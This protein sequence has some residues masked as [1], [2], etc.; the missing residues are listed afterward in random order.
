MI[1]V[2]FYTVLFTIMEKSVFNT[3]PSYEPPFKE[4]TPIV[5]PAPIELKVWYSGVLSSTQKTN[6]VAELC[7][8]ANLN[9]LSM[10]IDGIQDNS[11]GGF[12]PGGAI[13]SLPVDDALD[14]IAATFCY[15]RHPYD[16]DASFVCVWDRINSRFV[17]TLTKPGIT[18]I[19]YLRSNDDLLGVRTGTSGDIQLDTLIKINVS[20]G[21]SNYSTPQTIAKPVS[22]SAFDS[23]RQGIEITSMKYYSQGL[24]KI[25]SGE[26]GHSLC[27]SDLGDDRQNTNEP[28]TESNRFDPVARVSN[29]DLVQKIEC[30]GTRGQNSND[31]ALDPLHARDKSYSVYGIDDPTNDSEYELV[32]HVPFRDTQMTSR[33]VSTGSYDPDLNVVLSRLKNQTVDSVNHVGKKIACSGTEYRGAIFG[34]DS[35]AFGELHIR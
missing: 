17:Y 26:Y 28:F 10:T 32:A 16:G 30:D 27:R 6:V 7:T 3:N 8:G 29:I 13:L 15:S 11:A 31:G 1:H 21:A 2:Q 4:Y 14:Y 9:F 33:D 18:T 34:T 25:W 24:G 19:T 22:T 12:L 35:L 20:D 23:A 5:I